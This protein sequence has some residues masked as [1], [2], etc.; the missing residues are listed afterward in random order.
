MSPSIRRIPAASF[1]DYPPLGVA[2]FDHFGTAQFW[3]HRGQR[4]ILAPPAP[5]EARMY[6]SALVS[7]ILT[8][9]VLLT[10]CSGDDGIETS[11]AAADRPTASVEQAEPSTSAPTETPAEGTEDEGTDDQATDEATQHQAPTDATP[12]DVPPSDEA[13]TEGSPSTQESPTAEPTDDEGTPD[14]GA[15]DE[16]PTG[17]TEGLP[18][19]PIESVPVHGG[20]FWAAYLAVGAPGDPALQQVLGRVQQDWPG[21]SI[22][23]LGCDEGAA[24]ALGRAPTDQAVAVY[25]DTPQHITEFRRRWEAPFVGAV[26]VTTYC[27]D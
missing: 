3:R 9:A 8:T 12:S 11:A 13:P 15:I 4:V 22:G 19:W 6:R 5:Q 16:I 17:G 27:A 21:A 24:A 10:A 14:D 23:D 1:G 25:F 7:S 26:H 18:G 2:E 20:S